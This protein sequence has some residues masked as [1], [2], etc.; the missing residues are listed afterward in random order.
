M[1]L[2][3]E[4]HGNTTRRS[5][6]YHYNLLEFTW[7][8]FLQVEV[9]KDHVLMENARECLDQIVTALENLFKNRQ[10]YCYQSFPLLKN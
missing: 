10:K 1:Q 8:H 5:Q 6:L 7:N 9:E 2:E 4:I 3:N